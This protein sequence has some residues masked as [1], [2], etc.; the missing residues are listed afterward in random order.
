M[1][2]WQKTLLGVVVAVVL[3]LGVILVRTM[4]FTSKQAQFEGKVA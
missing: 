3:L 2:K 4:T 1:K